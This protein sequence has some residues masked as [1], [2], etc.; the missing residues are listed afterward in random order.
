MLLFRFIVLDFGMLVLDIMPIIHELHEERLQQVKVSNI[1]WLNR[2]F[3]AKWI[4]E[5]RNCDILLE[6]QVRQKTT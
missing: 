6:S 4:D 2:M 5:D 1:W 3:P